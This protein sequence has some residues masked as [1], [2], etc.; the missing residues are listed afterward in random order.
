M[1]SDRRRTIEHF[2]LSKMNSNDMMLCDCPRHPP[3]QPVWLSRRT[4]FRHQTAARISRLH[5]TAAAAASLGTAADGQ[6]M[7]E[8]SR[9]EG[10]GIEHDIA[11]AD[12][13][14]FQ[15]FGDGDSDGSGESD[16]MDE[17]ETSNLLGDL[18]D[19]VIYFNPP[20]RE[21]SPE[22]SERNYS[23]DSPKLSAESANCD[24]DANDFFGFDNE[25]LGLLQSKQPACLSNK[26]C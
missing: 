9:S 6:T 24:D 11:M 12:E 19:Y 3:G 1:K 4:F 22:S 5:D 15:E 13:L 16:R 25:D 21:Q 17:Q 20:G 26:K 10:E 18:N 23:F 14:A 7:E 8:D 2:R